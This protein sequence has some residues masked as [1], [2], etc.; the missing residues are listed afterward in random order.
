MNR[1]SQSSEDYLEAILNIRKSKGSCFSV[2]IADE[3]SVSRPSVSR[4]VKLLEAD[5]YITREQN[6]IILTE[7]GLEVA[8]KILERHLFF[9]KVFTLLGVDRGTAEHDACL[10]EHRI[11]DIS[12]QKIKERYSCIGKECV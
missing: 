8:Q 1:I 7:S 4:A 9:T 11:S 2:D 5:G 10:I 3:L 12:F 6:D